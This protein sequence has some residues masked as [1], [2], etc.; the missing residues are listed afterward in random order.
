M[1]VR[2]RVRMRDTRRLKQSRARHQNVCNF[3]TFLFLLNHFFFRPWGFGCLFCFVFSF[4]LHFFFFFWLS[5]FVC[6]RSMF[7]FLLLHNDVLNDASVSLVFGL[8]VLFCFIYLFFIRREFTSSCSRWCQQTQRSLRCLRA[9][10][11]LRL[12]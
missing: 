10:P 6:K 4:F 3:D 7:Y 5:R 9:I 1:H 8:F 11:R 12:S 2:L